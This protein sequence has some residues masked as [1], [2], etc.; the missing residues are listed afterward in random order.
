MRHVGIEMRGTATPAEPLF[1]ESRTLRSAP[2]ARGI[3]YAIKPAHFQGV[4]G[5]IPAGRGNR[6]RRSGSG[7]GEGLPLHH[8]QQC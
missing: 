6:R 1:L 2:Q 7:S 3:E 5:S 4:A 8:G